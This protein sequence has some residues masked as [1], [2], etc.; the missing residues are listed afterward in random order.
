MA[1]VIL[2]GLLLL[3][4]SPDSF[5]KPSKIKSRSE[6][7]AFK[8]E[9]VLSFFS[10]TGDNKIVTIDL[11]IADND[12]ERARGMMYRKNMDASTGMLFIMEREEYQSFWMRNTYVSLDILFLDKT[13]SIVHIEKYTQPLSDGSIPSEKRAKYV[14]EVKA[15]FCDR[16]GINTGDSI[17][18]SR[19]NE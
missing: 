11:E 18:Y 10:K 19:L 2:V 7:P 4:W 5:Q 17:R 13:F 8:K 9:G 16:H 6:A 3:T 1:V 15:G 14:L 12:F